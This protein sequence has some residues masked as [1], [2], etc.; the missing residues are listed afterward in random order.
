M[1]GMSLGH[2]PFSEIKAYAD[3]LEIPRSRR[4]ALFYTVYV[5]D[6]EYLS[7]H[8]KKADKNRKP[9]GH[10]KTQSRSQQRRSH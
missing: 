9:N 4:D 1:T 7:F 6:R 3:E 8:N 10:R 5:L 2:I